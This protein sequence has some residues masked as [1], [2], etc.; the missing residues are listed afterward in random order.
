MIRRFLHDIMTRL[1]VDTDWLQER[2]RQQTMAEERTIQIREDIRSR[3]LN[4]PFEDDIFVPIKPYLAEER[5][6]G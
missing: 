6:Q 2:E 1:F 4:P 3:E 5:R